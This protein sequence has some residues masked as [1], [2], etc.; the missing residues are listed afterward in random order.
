MKLSIIIPIYNE[1]NLIKKFVDNL[2]QTFKE[3]DA[4]YIFIDDGS[5]DGSKEW[6]STNISTYKDV[7][8]YIILDNAHNKGKGFAIRKGIKEVTGDYVLLIDSDMEYDPRDGLEMF[9]IIKSE[10]NMNVL[11]GSRYMGGKIQHRKHVLNDLAVRL[12]TLIFNFLFD[13]SITDLHCGTKIISKKIL[14]K[15]K[16]TIN[17]FGFEIDLS[18]KIA[19]S[20]QKIYEYGISYIGRTVDEGKKITVVD[21][22]LSY[23]YL[24]K[25]RFI[26]NDLSTKISLIYTSLFMAYIGSY[27]GMDEGKILAIIFFGL[28]GL[29]IGLSRKLFTSSIV[30]LF[31]YI[32]SLF[33]KGNGRIYTIILFLLFGI[34]ITK[35]I[36]KKFYKSKK[37]YF[38]KYFI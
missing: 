27:F 25:T 33:S 6:L 5:T 35:K 14:D 20:D 3:I 22:L 36:T 8:N 12:N 16:L 28:F 13:Q 7:K 9:E 15:I 38:W 11:F 24:F 18:S 4:E 23:Y 1:V 31:I 29:I 10:K 37:H 2:F 30:F 34:Y 21:G 32:G 17:D 26:Q 19:I